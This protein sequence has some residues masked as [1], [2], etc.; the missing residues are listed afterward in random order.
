MEFDELSQIHYKPSNFAEVFYK[1]KTTQEKLV[2]LN[3][4]GTSH[5]AFIK[6]DKY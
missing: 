6:F 3:L 4:I 1:S 2:N 5:K